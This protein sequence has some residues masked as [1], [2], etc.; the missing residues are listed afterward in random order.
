MRSTLMIVA[1]CLAFAGCAVRNSGFSVGNYTVT[2]KCS[3]TS[4]GE[5]V[6]TSAVAWSCNELTGFFQRDRV[7]AICES[8]AECNKVC[9]EAQAE[10]DREGK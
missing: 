7:V 10:R 3:T 1:A 4:N 5:N 6:C 8:A 9:A 2:R